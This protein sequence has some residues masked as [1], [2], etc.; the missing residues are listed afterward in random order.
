METAVSSAR[1]ESLASTQRRRRHAGVALWPIVL[2][3]ALV[4]SACGSAS[5][6][7]TS[8][9]EVDLGL[10]VERTGA[11]GFAGAMFEN[12]FKLAID[13]ANDG[14]ALPEGYTVK[15]AVENTA[16][17]PATAVQLFNRMAA[18]KEIVG[19]ACCAHTPFSDPLA[20]IA[21]RHELPVVNY[22][23][24][25]PDIPQ[26]PYVYRAG[27]DTETGRAGPTGNEALVKKLVADLGVSRTVVVGSTDKSSSAETFEVW[28][29]SVANAGGE[30]VDAISVPSDKTN[31]NDTA[32]SVVAE[33]PDLVVAGL[34]GVQGA[35][36]VK[37]LRARG[38]EGPVAGSYAFGLPSLFETAG[39]SLNDTYYSVAF[40]ATLQLPAAQD[41]AAAFEEEFDTEPE[42]WAAQGYQAGRLMLAGLS[43]AIESGEVTRE[44]LAKGL[45][46]TSEF[47]S[48]FGDGTTHMK[49]GAALLP[50]TFQYFKWTA[51]G[52]QEEIK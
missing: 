10:L 30:L 2:V 36:L 24:T 32:A 16:S 4:L 48:V 37:A 23:L 11:L 19:V 26:P 42:M 25:G 46:D 9:K 49:D 15:L 20:P 40:S 5:S 41:M 50:A 6:G 31:L 51:D 52:Q 18:N 39:A 33:S 35:L 27:L 45:E 44:S 13:E 29:E 22:S 8:D 14:G 43:K 47:P 1:P 38:Y 21:V 17:E 34:T 28:K 3:A 7:A 12:G